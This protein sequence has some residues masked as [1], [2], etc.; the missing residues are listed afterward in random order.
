[1]LHESVL[2]KFRTVQWSQPNSRIGIHLCQD[3]DCLKYRTDFWRTLTYW[4]RKQGNE[5]IW[6][7]VY[8]MSLFEMKIELSLEGF[9]T[10]MYERICINQCREYFQYIFDR[11]TRIFRY[12][13]I[14]SPWTSIGKD[15]YLI[16]TYCP[17]TSL[18][19]RQ[20]SIRNIAFNW[21]SKYKLTGFI[22]SPMVLT[23]NNVVFIKHNILDICLSTNSPI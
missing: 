12:A 6:L 10:Q 8:N 4:T 16:H 23:L 21:M 14:E 15:Q 11:G 13:F 18:M 5:S 1:M 20:K 3:V 22:S 7:F 17:W 9:K 19:C 2:R